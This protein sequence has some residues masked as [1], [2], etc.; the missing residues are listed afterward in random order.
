MTAFPRYVLTAVA[1]LLTSERC[2]YWNYFFANA[3]DSTCCADYPL[4]N[5]LC[6]CTATQC[7]FADDYIW[8]WMRKRNI[9]SKINEG[10]TKTYGIDLVDLI[11]K[12][13]QCFEDISL[14]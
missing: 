6:R 13:I 7:Y 10:G 2:C 9:G 11:T 8:Y 3:E 12:G 4:Q 14:H 1:I 5:S